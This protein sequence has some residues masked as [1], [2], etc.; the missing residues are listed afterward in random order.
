MSQLPFRLWTAINRF[1]SI[2][3]LGNAGLTRK[4]RGSRSSKK[5]SGN[6]D[7]P[8][9]VQKT[10]WDSSPHS[11][12]HFPGKLSLCLGMPIMIRN[13]DATELCIT[14]GQ[15]AFVAGWD[16]IVM[17]NG[18]KTLETLFLELNN[19][20]KD[21]ELPHLPKNVIPMTRTSKKIKCFLPNDYEINIIR[22][23]INVLPNFSMTD[24]ASQGKTRPYNVVNL[25]H[26]KNFQS[27]YTCLS[28]SSSAA[29]TLIIQGL[30]CLA[31][32]D[33]NSES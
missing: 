17:P 16:T 15:E 1:Y 21:I 8:I 4:K 19:P 5:T 33:K 32:C 23:Q 25:S 7:I 11:S 12:E 27:I 14:K 6:V 26:C 18:L 20:P 31:I 2:D 24:Y 22:Q 3:K 28:R 13:N 10:L 30:D 29:G 9:D